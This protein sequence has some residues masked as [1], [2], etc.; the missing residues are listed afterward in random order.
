MGIFGLFAY[1]GAF[2]W[3]VSFIM[4]G[5]FLQEGWRNLSVTMHNITIVA[6]LMSTAA[7]LVVYLLRR[8]QS[9]DSSHAVCTGLK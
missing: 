2:F 4:L 8:R 7:A 3:S 9:S 1:T 6:L 5:Y